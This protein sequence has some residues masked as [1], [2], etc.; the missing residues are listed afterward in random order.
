MNA[1]LAHQGP[2]LEFVRPGYA[3]VGRSSAVEIC[4]WTRSAILGGA[5]C[6]KR[7]YGVSSHRC[8]QMTPN[9]SLCNF[10]CPFC[11]RPHGSRGEPAE[12]DG[13]DEVV[14]GAVRAQRRL[15]IGYKGNASADMR[16]FLEAMF[17]RHFAISL[18]GEPTIYPWLRELVAAVRSRGMTAFLVTNGSLPGRLRE[19]RAVPPHNLYV[20]LYG[21]SEDML[22]RAARPAF[23]GAWERVMESVSMMSDFESA[24]SNTVLR[25]TLVRGLN[26]ADPDGY[27]RAIASGSPMFVELKGYTWVGES[28]RR[29]S[30]DAMPTLDELRTF[31]RELGA[32][33]GY[34]EAE[35]DPRSRVVMLARDAESL[36]TARERAARLRA[37]IEE[38]DRG[39]R[40]RYGDPSE[41]RLDRGNL[42]PWPGGWI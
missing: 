37:R 35:V 5:A 38:L 31:A 14:E 9:A 28:T 12:W 8:V 15:L 18:D 27:A 4:R 22:E 20:S 17:P 24:G 3:R 34:L 30:I 1:G 32:R 40:E 19:L 16:R 21:S 11:W 26:M 10:R 6:Y 42:P 13:P 7:W 25:L 29:L 39:W 41:F 33:T 36:E 23:R 2:A